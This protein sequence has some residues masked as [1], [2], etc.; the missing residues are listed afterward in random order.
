[1]RP[2]TRTPRARKADRRSLAIRSLGPC[3]GGARR[4]VRWIDH[5]SD[6]ARPAESLETYTECAYLELLKTIPASAV[7]AVFFSHGHADHCA[8]LNPLLRARHFSEDPPPALPLFALAGAL[9]AVLS[10]DGQMLAHDFVAHE[11]CASDDF[12]VG[13]FHLTT[14]ALSHSVPN[15]G[16]RLEVGGIA[17]C[18]TGDGGSDPG[19]VDLALDAQLLLAEATFAEIVPEASRGSLASARHAGEHAC[20]AG[21]GQL[22]LTHLLPGTDPNAAEQEAARHFSGPV[23]VAEPGLSLELS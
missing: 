19:V 13:P 18:Y 2:A 22:V 12:T 17:V 15:V 16:V 10:L 7:D 23:T 1:M 11:F 9:D 6:T 20:A 21:V 14:R 5:P 3:Y 8:D 4:Q